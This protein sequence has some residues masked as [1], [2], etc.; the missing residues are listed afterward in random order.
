MTFETLSTTVTTSSTEN[1]GQPTPLLQ[2]LN[3]AIAARRITNGI[4]FLINLVFIVRIFVSI[5]SGTKLRKMY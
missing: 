1:C 4:S 5:K 3:E 2:E